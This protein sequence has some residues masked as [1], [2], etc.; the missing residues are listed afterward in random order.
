[1]HEIEWS[2]SCRAMQAQDEAKEGLGKELN[3]DQ[4]GQAMDQVGKFHP[5]HPDY[6]EAPSSS[7]STKAGA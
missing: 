7:E 5:D 6:P 3:E 1:M 4:G 2:S